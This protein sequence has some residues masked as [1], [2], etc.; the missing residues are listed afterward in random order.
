MGS[1]DALLGKKP[2]LQMEQV[3]SA[4]KH[5]TSN[6]PRTFLWCGDSDTTVNPKNTRIMYAALQQAKVP[7]QCRIY[8]NVPHGVG[9]AKGTAAEN[10]MQEALPFWL[11]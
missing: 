6:Y 7:C 9:I 10:W 2:N 4:E 3:T 5:V 8:P 1:H 11:E